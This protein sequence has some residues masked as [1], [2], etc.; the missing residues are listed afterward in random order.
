MSR[1]IQEK[2]V[3]FELTNKVLLDDQTWGRL[4]GRIVKDEDMDV[5][6]AERIVD[7]TI[8]FLKLA[9]TS[10]GKAYSPS[11]MVDIGWHT[12]IL[13][14]REYAVFCEK[15][16]GRFI[17]HSPLDVEGEDYSA[18]STVGETASAMK[19][20]GIAVDEELWASTHGSKCDIACQE[21]I[22]KTT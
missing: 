1:S 11:P 6:L 21:K 4:V 10:N 19:V 5:A 2:A 14:T 13:Y 16:A 9:S 18:S 3:R 8:G 17:H 20:R 12:F 15:I 7:Q 22:C